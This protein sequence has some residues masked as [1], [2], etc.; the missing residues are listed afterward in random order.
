MFGHGSVAV[1]VPITSMMGYDVVVMADLDIGGRVGQLHFLADVGVR[2]AVIVDVLVKTRIT[3]LIDRSDD[4]L[5]HLVTEWVQ[6]AESLLFHILEVVAAGQ[7][8]VVVLLKSRMD[9]HIERTQIRTMQP[10]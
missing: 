1:V 4:M 3:V 9:R 8:L 10:K 2:D 7:V 6:G 5:L